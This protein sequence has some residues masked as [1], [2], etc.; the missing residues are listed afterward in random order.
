MVSALL[1]RCYLLIDHLELDKMRL[2]ANIDVF[3]LNKRIMPQ[4]WFVTLLT[5][6][7]RQLY[8]DFVNCSCTEDAT[9][10]SWR[11]VSLQARR[12]PYAGLIS[13]G[14]WAFHKTWS[15]RISTAENIAMFGVSKDSQQF[16]N[17]K[18]FLNALQRKLTSMIIEGD[19]KILDGSSSTQYMMGQV[20]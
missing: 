20:M 6:I 11:F 9:G 13:S 18:G 15:S 1:L 5:R 14:Y 12:I 7:R 19:L 2:V 10:K 3:A 4:C 16:A 8:F 17:R